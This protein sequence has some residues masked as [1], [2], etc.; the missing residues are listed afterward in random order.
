MCISHD[1]NDSIDSG[2]RRPRLETLSTIARNKD[3][4][5]SNWPHHE[6]KKSAGSLV[7]DVDD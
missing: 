3:R 4:G 2:M 6:V 5:T 1:L 7:V